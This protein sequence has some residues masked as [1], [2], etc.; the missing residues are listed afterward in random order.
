M[1]I[2]VLFGAGAS[3]GAGSVLPSIPPLGSS[4]YQELSS[5]FPATWGSLPSSLKV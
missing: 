5:M 4:L 2:I 3:Y 1:S